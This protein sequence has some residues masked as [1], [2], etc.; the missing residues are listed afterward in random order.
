MASRKLAQQRVLRIMQE[1]SSAPVDRAPIEPAADSLQVATPRHAAKA[2]PQDGAT[3]K[4]RDGL[5]A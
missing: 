4:P 1:Q 2:V 5:S 3:A